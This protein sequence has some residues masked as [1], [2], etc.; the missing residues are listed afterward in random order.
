MKSLVDAAARLRDA[1]S[2]FKLK[3]DRIDVPEFYFGAKLQEMQINAVPCWTVA[4]HNYKLQCGGACAPGF[5]RVYFFHITY[6]LV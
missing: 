6:S 1:Q 5:S 4:S 2:T 3:N